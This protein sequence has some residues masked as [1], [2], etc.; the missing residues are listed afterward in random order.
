[1]KITETTIP[2]VKILEPKYFQDDR[3]YYC[4]T[5]SKQTLSEFGIN[6]IFVQDNHAYSKKRGIIRGIHFQ[7][8]PQAQTKLVRCVVGSVMDF[9]IDL[10]KGSPTYKKW[11]SVE[12]NKENHKQIYIPKGF[13]HAYI[14]LTQESEV[15]YKVDNFYFPNLDRAISYNDPEI[16]IDWGND[17]PVISQKDTR[18]PFLKDSDI[19]FIYE[20]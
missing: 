6:D 7:N 15:L 8:N 16:A 17:A 10:R 13:G 1:M 11:I 3:G 2:D 5:Y 19:N 14:T 20:R 18:A 9:A 12:L 4:E